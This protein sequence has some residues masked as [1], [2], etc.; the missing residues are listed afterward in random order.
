MKHIST[1]VVIVGGGL[2]GLTVGYYLKKAGI[3]F[4]IIEKQNHIGG[5]ISTISEDGFTYE[6]GPN[7]GVLN[8][9]EIMN[10]FDSLKDRCTLSVARRE[11]N[12]RY[13][14]FRNQWQ[15]LPS[16]LKQGI[17][18]PLF[19]WNDKLR[20]LV[21]PFRRKGKDPNETLSEMV[22]RR[23]GQ[24]FLDNAVDP[25]ISGI[26]AGDPSQLITRH[27]LPKLYKLEQDYGSFIGGAI[28]KKT[29]RTSEPNKFT[30]EVFSCTNGLQSLTDGMYEFIGNS[31]VLLNC[32][33]VIVDKSDN[34]FSTS[35]NCGD[36]QMEIKSSFVVMATNAPTLSESLAFIDQKLKDSIETMIYA[37]VVLA[38]AGFKHWDGMP[39]DAFG[40]LIPSKADKKVLGVLFPSAIFANRAPK[41][42]ALLSIFLGGIRY[43]NL[44]DKS[45]ETIRKLVVNELKILMK[46]DSFEPDLFK[47]F[48]HKKA[49]PQYDISMDNRLY[50]IGQLE[51]NNSGLFIGG[52]IRDGIGMSDRIKQAV[53]IANQIIK[54]R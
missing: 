3:P 10:L 38:V 44:V 35:L 26:Y 22:K 23:M 42:G 39:L 47:I 48:R 32:S 18:T 46:M 16:G 8:N 29:E 41:E 24:S 52:N 14:Y 37:P 50:L 5:V 11:A 6:T 27:A 34:S 12:K 4:V 19:T 51:E 49:I 53:N 21:E 9:N 40:G 54:Q 7:T 1:K 31:S 45:D 25:F 15:A 20:L 28:R 33:R 17:S 2:T 43:P 36:G 13:I 30:K